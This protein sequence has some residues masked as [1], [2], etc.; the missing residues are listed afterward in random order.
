MSTSLNSKLSYLLLGLIV[1]AGFL[2]RVHHLALSGF[3]VDEMFHVDAAKSI[4]ATG[5]PTLEGGRI[6]TRAWPFTYV[7]VAFF[8]FFGVSEI[9]ARIPAVIFG[10]LSI[11]LTFYVA[12]KW[13]DRPTALVASFLMTFSPL[14]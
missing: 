13:F 5:Q 8:K 2:I 12:R 1:A 7:I 4:L 6:Y 14:S 11:V 9:S 3:W 10:V